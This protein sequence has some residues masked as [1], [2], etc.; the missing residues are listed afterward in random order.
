MRNA[1]K[2]IF[3]TDFKIGSKCE[4]SPFYKGTKLWNVLN[5]DTQ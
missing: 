3:K 4:N 2:F 1:N 5:R